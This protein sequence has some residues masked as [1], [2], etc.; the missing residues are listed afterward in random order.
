MFSSAP[1]IKGKDKTYFGM[2]T[3]SEADRQQK[4]KLHLYLGGNAL[5]CTA[6]PCLLIR[7]MLTLVLQGIGRPGYREIKLVS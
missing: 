5:E 3:Q 7:S 2:V 1:L 6:V 4:C